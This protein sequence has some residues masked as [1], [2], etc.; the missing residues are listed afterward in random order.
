MISTKKMDLHRLIF[1]VFQRLPNGNEE[2]TKNISIS[3]SSSSFFHLLL[4]GDWLV[5]E[6]WSPR[7]RRFETFE[8]LQCGDAI[9]TP[10]PQPE[11]PAYL[12]LSVITG[13][14]FPA[15]VVLPGS[16]QDMPLRQER[17]TEGVVQPVSGFK[18]GISGM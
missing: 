8:F 4:N 7:C 12:C 9:P 14:T 2:S 17:P 13:K 10:N 11:G 1:V 18:P 16:R 3:S 5:F 6:P 15:W